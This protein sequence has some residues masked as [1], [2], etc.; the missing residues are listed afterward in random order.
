M[1]FKDFYIEKGYSNVVTR[2]KKSYD[3]QHMR[4]N[5]QFLLEDFTLRTLNHLIEM[6]GVEIFYDWSIG[7]RSDRTVEDNL[8]NGYT[9]G[10]YGGEYSIAQYEDDLTYQ[11]EMVDELDDGSK[12]SLYFHYKDYKNEVVGVR[13]FINDCLPCNRYPNGQRSNVKFVLQKV[14]GIIRIAILTCR[15]IRG[16]G[17]VL[18][19]NYGIDYWR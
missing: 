3:E 12:V 10:Y 15:T 1:T 19:F 9:I 2:W 16:K 5:E 18:V 4:R 14:D 13:P 6:N 7:C 17:T 11:I 8:P